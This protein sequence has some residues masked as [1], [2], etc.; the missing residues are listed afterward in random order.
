MHCAAY[1]SSNWSTVV[2]I[3]WGK[4]LDYLLPFKRVHWS[5][6]VCQLNV[7]GHTRLSLW[8]KRILMSSHHD[9]VSAR[10]FACLIFWKHKVWAVSVWRSYPCRS[11]TTVTGEHFVP[12]TWGQIVPGI[13]WEW[14]IKKCTLSQDSDLSSNFHLTKYFWQKASHVKMNISIHGT[15]VFQFVSKWLVS[16]SVSLI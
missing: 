5:L 10:F 7:Q 9:C 3:G 8:N 1:Y 2:Y 14:Q 16:Q 13:I 4:Q 6:H 15:A 12:F 11:F